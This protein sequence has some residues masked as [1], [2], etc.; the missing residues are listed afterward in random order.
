MIRT[1]CLTVLTL[2]LTLGVWAGDT[3]RVMSY[4]IRMNTSSDGVNAWPHRKDKV[5][6]MIGARYQ[7]DVAGLQEVLVEQL[8]DLEE[9][10]PDYAHIGVAR[11]D[12]KEAG[13]FSPILYRKDRFELLEQ[14]TFW[15]SESPD[16]AGTKSWDSACNRVCTWGKF[17]EKESGKIFFAFNTHLDHISQAARDNGTLLIWRILNKV[18]GTHPVVLT[19][20]FN[21][22]ENSFPIQFLTGK[23]NS[24]EMQ[25]DLKNTRYITETPATGPVVTFTSWDKLGRGDSPIDYIFVR[26]GFSVAEHHHLDDKYGDFFPSDHLPVLSVL[27]FE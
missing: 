4:N 11:D 20:D 17:K 8:R 9:R 15:L 5:A 12:G 22:R 25:S 18:S 2:C 6:E 14:K 3:L 13:E 16:V 21:S 19:G 24:G 10:L 23:A 7:A 1:L 27:K 26:N